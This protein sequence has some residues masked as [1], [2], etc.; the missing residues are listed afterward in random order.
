MN[1]KKMQRMLSAF[2]DNE[3]GEVWTKLVQEHL[4]EC[5]SCQ[6]RLQE[7]RSIRAR[8]RDAATVDLPDNFLYSVQRSIRREEQESVM[9]LG[10]E[11]FARNVVFALCVLVFG[12]V[13]FGSLLEPQP[14]L[15]EDRYISGEPS[16]SA[17]HAVLG[18][19]QVISKEDVMIAAL[20]K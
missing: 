11:R 5:A 16:D 3:L 19:E 14:T 20:S 7:L 15:G 17:A 10:T 1:H 2:V 9:W 12:V 18:S 4:V 8:I 6:Q 13:A